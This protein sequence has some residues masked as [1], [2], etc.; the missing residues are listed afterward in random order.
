MLMIFGGSTIRIFLNGK[1]KTLK[2]DYGSVCPLVMVSGFSYFF[3]VVS[4]DEMA[5]PVFGDTDWI[6]PFLEDQEC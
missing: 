3:W 2:I 4:G 1:I 6:P 5:N